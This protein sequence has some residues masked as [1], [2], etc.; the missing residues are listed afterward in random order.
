MVARRRRQRLNGMVAM[1]GFYIYMQR[2]SWE[3]CERALI[4]RWGCK[5]ALYGVYVYGRLIYPPLYCH[6]LMHRH[7][8]RFFFI[9][10]VVCFFF[11]HNFIMLP[12]YIARVIKNVYLKF[13]PLWNT[14]GAHY[15]LREH[16]SRG[17]ANLRATVG[18]MWLVLCVCR[19]V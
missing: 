7:D 10:F 16:E 11:L 8:Q 2:K 13:M 5:G 4:G 14:R 18:E 15:V 17:C 9:I 1:C 12:M 3:I 6:Y 19:R